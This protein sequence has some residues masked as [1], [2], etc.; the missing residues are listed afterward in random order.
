MLFRVISRAKLHKSKHEKKRKLVMY[1]D[2]KV[3]HLVQKFL[4]LTSLVNLVLIH[5]FL[6]PLSHKQIQIHQ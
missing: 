6:S 1:F 5:C 4:V 3:T 2:K